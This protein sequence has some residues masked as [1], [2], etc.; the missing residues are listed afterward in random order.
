[1]RECVSQGFGRN[2][3]H[4]V[5][6]P[7]HF[8]DEKYGGRDRESANEEGCKN[9]GVTRC[10]QSEARENDHEPERE[11][12]EEWHRKKLAVV[13]V[14]LTLLPVSALCQESRGVLNDTF[15]IALGSFIVDTDTA[16][17]L[18]GSAGEQGQEVDWEKNFGDGDV[19]RFRLD[20][21]WRFADR[22]KLRA[23]V[24]SSSREGSNTIDEDIEWGG[25]TFPANATV[26]GEVKFSVYELAYEYAFMRRETFELA[27]SFGLHYTEYEASLG[28]TVTSPVG[29]AD[30][31]IDRGGSVG[32]P[33]PVFG[34]RGTWS[35]SETFTIDL[36]GQYFALTY[37]D[38]DGN[39]QDYRVLVNWQPS[40]W[41]GL[42]IGYDHFSM[43]VN[44]DGSAF[45]GKMDWVYQGPMI[46]YSASF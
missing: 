35:L 41:L 25:E 26:D 9:R 37:G 32:A 6:R 46:F 36:A 2:R 43:N 31:R 45:R 39:L 19:N 16:L 15:N 13:I 30:T 23:L 24:F 8:Q 21:F 12:N 18:D 42:G 4:A 17:R 40:N 28:A 11:N 7:I 22:H 38:F 14:G 44:V 29:G 1:M 3:E 5:E 34:L 10:E 20:G 27:G 33:L